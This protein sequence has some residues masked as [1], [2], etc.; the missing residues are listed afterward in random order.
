MTV[1]PDNQAR[2]FAGIR[3]SAIVEIL[4]FLVVMLSIDIFFLDGN[5]YWNTAPHPFWAIVLLVS[6]QY[7]TREGV[8][9]AV[10]CSL[11]L[12]LG[13]L[14]GQQP[15][16]DLYSWL[17]LIA[18][19]PLTWLVAAVLLGELRMRHIREREQL[20]H[21]L[22][23]A[24]EREATVAY[25]YD[26]VRTLKEKLELRIA[27]QLKSSVSTYRAAQAIEK[28][29]PQEVL[30]GVQD[31]VDAA[32]SPQRFSLFML[33]EKE[34][35]VAALTSGWH[36]EDN[37]ARTFSTRSGIYQ[38]VVGNKQTLVVANSDHEKLL[39]NQGVLA[40]PLIDPA[41]G[42]VLG[43]L[44][45]ESLGFTELH[46]SSIETFKAIC[47]WVG[48][49]LV[50]ARKYEAAQKSSVINPDHNL[51]TYGYFQRYRDHIAAL[52]KRVGFDVSSVTINLTH[53]DRLDNAS[54]AKIAKLLSESVDAVLRTVDLA[55]DHQQTGETYA[56]VMPATSITGARVVMEKIESELEKRVGKSA[57][58][59]E[60][61]FTLQAIHEHKHAK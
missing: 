9:S 15:S 47:E 54:R 20:K 7:G 22:V 49:A 39:D 57:R 44:K 59:A 27:G 12:L 18:A 51:F 1:T 48:M 25:S 10:A 46:L 60:F 42:E 37:F 11:A 3:V 5:R 14:P 32:L 43:M 41:T 53:A 34:G 29:H 26:Q 28:L 58:G 24:R 30:R 33:N 4:L 45:I 23:A 36:E 13:N 55:F 16:Q 2:T 52:A 38:Q 31:L 8:L 6:T 21:D 17:F 19:T 40:G 35:L 61:S 50:N 56:I